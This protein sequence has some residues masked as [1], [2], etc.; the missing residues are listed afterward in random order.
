MKS[1][2]RVVTI[3]KIK[4][5]GD[6][7]VTIQSM[8]NSRT[9]E[10]E[11]TV[12]QIKELK[13]SGCEIVRIAVPDEES[14]DAI[15]SLVSLANV[16]LVADIHFD[17]RL[18]IKSIKSGVHKVRINPGNIGAEW[19]VKEVVKVAK[20][21]HIP[22]RV[23]AN[24]G[25]IKS[26]FKQYSP[27]KALAESALSEVRLLERTSFEEIVIS[28]KSSDVNETIKANEYIHSKVDY[29]LHIGITESGIGL[30]G[31]VKSALGIGIL[32]SKGIGDTIRVSL[33]G[34][35]VKEVMVAKS[36][37]KSLGIKS[38]VS[39][40][41]CPTCGRAEIDVEKIAMGI[42]RVT[43]NIDENIKIAVMGCVV[44]GI[45]EGSNSDIGIAGTKKG[46]AIF[47]NGEI[48]ETVKKN[49]IEDS[50]MKYLEQ[51]KNM[52]RDNA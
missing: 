46:A 37:L 2:K 42:E 41:A 24:S 18:A 19:K 25:S 8:T 13:E 50:L 20:Q 40:I 36:I 28:A 16:P 34:N 4:I 47:I 30:D 43:K 49:E 51:I 17:Y 5:G 45:G 23:G 22:V 31:T 48:I 35:P 39:I 32:L 15:K 1:K 21:Y 14:A 11:N 44:N 52:R 38:G 6:F 3:G 26:D 27:E 29:P 10:I 7:P 9:N 33:P 12:S